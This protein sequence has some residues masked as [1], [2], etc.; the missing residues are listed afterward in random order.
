MDR[1]E[2]P[3]KR[4]DLLDV[5]GLVLLG[6]ATL[7][8][9]ALALAGWSLARQALPFLAGALVGD[10][11]MYLA[12]KLVRYRLPLVIAALLLVT[13]GLILSFNLWWSLVGGSALKIS[14]GVPL[15]V[16]K[17]ALGLTLGFGGM[18]LSTVVIPSFVSPTTW[19]EAVEQRRDLVRMTLIVGGISAALLV[20]VVLVIG[21]LTL[22]MHAVAAFSNS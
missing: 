14:W 22:I 4:G 8:C 19:E 15:V 18:I 13:L 6:L 10:G 5:A 17:F 11:L 12:I 2:V 20:L 3:P 1:E 9:A 21:I 16:Q 7:A